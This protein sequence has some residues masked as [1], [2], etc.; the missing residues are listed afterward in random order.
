[1]SKETRPDYTY[2]WGSTGTVSTPTNGKIQ[3]GWVVEKPT[4][5]Y[6]NFI[7]NR[8][9]QAIS[10]LMQQ[11]IPEWVATIE[12]QS[13]SSFVTYNGN[14]YVS[15]QTG[16]NKNP[17][18][19][20]AYWT[21]YTGLA[22]SAGTTGKYR[23]VGGVIRQ[24]PVPTFAHAY[25]GGGKVRK[26]G[27]AGTVNVTS[28]VNNGAGKVRVSTD[29]AHTLIT[30]D[31]CNVYD[32][33]G[34][35]EANGGWSVTVI[36]ST[37]FDITGKTWA[38]INDSKHSPVNFEDVT[39][40]GSGDLVLTYAF[41]ATKK[42]GFIAVPD[43]TFAG[44]GMT[45]GCSVGS[46][47]AILSLFA[48]L[49][50]TINASGIQ[51][52]TPLGHFASGAC[53]QTLNASAG[54]L[55]VTHPT[56]SHSA[57]TGTAVMLS[58][59]DGNGRWTA[60]STKSGF[61][62]KYT[63]RVAGYVN[64]SGGFPLLNTQIAYPDALTIASGDNNGSGLYQLTFTAPHS[65]VTGHRATISGTGTALD[66][67]DTATSR[68]WAV[69]VINSTTVDLVGSTY[70]TPI[71]SGAAA[72]TQVEWVTDHLEIFHPYTG[73]DQ[74]CQVTQWKS[75]T[76]YQYTVDTPTAYKI[77]VWVYSS[78]GSAVT[79]KDSQMKL[80]YE[81]DT[82]LPATIPATAVGHVQR[83]DVHCHADYVYSANGNIW[84]L[85]LFEI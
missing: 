49:S 81:R 26:I 76:Q 65:F 12:Y 71:A 18:S 50:G 70:S 58:P 84:I 44:W 23:I 73:T 68:S 7:E 63:R 45:L 55:S 37:T 66:S 3:Q 60:S 9:D 62:L 54:T 39:V 46:D 85:G 67:G 61:D 4:F 83:D 13:G 32:V 59:L 75:A 33:G 79:T 53:T 42:S 56:M 11:G 48:P 19:E 25:T 51:D 74:P 8:Q 43:E 72:F 27:A 21:L 82:F 15:I 5:A 29:S 22:V 35:T 64:W 34:T 16:T 20:T 41:T 10:Y 28:C 17:A 47:D 78:S 1:M 2:K 69:T 77:P 24:S 14:I 36:D 52:S 80:M 30:G 31:R 6:W 38:F 40:D 57:G